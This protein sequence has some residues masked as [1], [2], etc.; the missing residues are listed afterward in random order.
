[1]EYFWKYGLKKMA[2]IVLFYVYI[3]AR[4]IFAPLNFALFFTKTIES[5]NFRH[6]RRWDCPLYRYDGTKTMSVGG[7]YRLLT[8]AIPL[9]EPSSALDRKESL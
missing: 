4:F 6:R 2:S 7:T 9:K 3:Y 1:M 5:V 8:E